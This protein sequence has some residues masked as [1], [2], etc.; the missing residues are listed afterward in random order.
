[1]EDNIDLLHYEKRHL[2]KKWQVITADNGQKALDI[3]R[4]SAV[5]LIVSDVMM[6]PKD[7]YEF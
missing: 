4:Q 5:D 2:K 7:G 6:E 3:L 1:M